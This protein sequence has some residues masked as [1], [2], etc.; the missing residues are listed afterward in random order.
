L[1]VRQ[2]AERGICARAGRPKHR[3]RIDFPGESLAI[4]VYD[5]LI[6][7]VRKPPEA[8]SVAVRLPSERDLQCKLRMQPTTLYAVLTTIRSFGPTGC[9]ARELAAK[10]WP[11][12]PCWSQKRRRGRMGSAAGGLL[13]KVRLRGHVVR[14]GEGRFIRYA[15]SAGGVRFVDNFVRDFVDPVANP[16]GDIAP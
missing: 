1:R 3:L 12:S 4:A 6:K 5:A 13:G 9:T 10:L 2:G 8:L 16:P 11:D 7:A 15:V 14:I